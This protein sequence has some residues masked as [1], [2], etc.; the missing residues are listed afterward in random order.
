MTTTQ[1]WTEWTIL[2][3]E[4]HGITQRSLEY[5]EAYLDIVKAMKPY[6]VIIDFGRTFSLEIKCE[7]GVV[8]LSGCNCGYGGTGPHGS[9]KALEM[10][11]GRRLTPPEEKF[12]F[13]HDH[14]VVSLRS[15]YKI[16]YKV[17]ARPDSKGDSLE[18][19]R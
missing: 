1:T 7:R 11:L 17:S 9:V 4:G 16:V 19:E 5:L 2:H 3:D 10:L 15:P 8:L 13:T 18:V 12:I 14:V 6:E